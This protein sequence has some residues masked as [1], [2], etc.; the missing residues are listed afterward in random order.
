MN[1]KMERSKRGV[2]LGICGFLRVFVVVNRGAIVVDC[3]AN[4]VC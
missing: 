3:V 4:V 2:C 1:K